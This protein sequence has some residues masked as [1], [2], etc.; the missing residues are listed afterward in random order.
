MS[1]Q[2]KGAEDFLR[3]SKALKAAGRK[4]LRKDLNKGLRDAAKPLIAQT[5]ASARDRLPKAGGLNDLVAKTPQRVQ[6]RTGATAGVRIVV[7]QSRSGARRANRGILRHPVFA[8]PNKPRDE[9]TWVDQKVN[10]EWFDGP[11]REGAPLVIPRLTAA[12]QTVADRVVR[13]VQRG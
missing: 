8:D 2:V 13:E 11:L 5:R 3:L 6:I 7:V 12:M 9:W 1:A 10:S 4:Q